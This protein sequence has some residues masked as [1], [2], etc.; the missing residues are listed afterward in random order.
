MINKRYSDAEKA[1]WIL[2][3]GKPEYVM[4]YERV[5]DVVFERPVPAT[6]KRLPPWIDKERRPVYERQPGQNWEHKY[7]LQE[8]NHGTY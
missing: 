5:D 2:K 3:N 7:K 4:I 6:G 1:E 8:D